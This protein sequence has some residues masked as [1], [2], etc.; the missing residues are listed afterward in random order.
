MFVTT[1]TSQ[2]LLS[3]HKGKKLKISNVCVDMAINHTHT[4]TCTYKNQKKAVT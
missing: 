3:H 1:T 2:L 4:C